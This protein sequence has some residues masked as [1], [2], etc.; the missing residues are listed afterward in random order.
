MPYLQRNAKGIWRVRRQIPDDVRHAFNDI[1]WFTESLGTRDPREADEL[2]P[3]SV[4]KTFGTPEL[5]L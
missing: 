3:L 2:A 1:K 5:V 4:V